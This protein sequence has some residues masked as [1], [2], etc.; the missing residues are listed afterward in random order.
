MARIFDA[1]NKERSEIAYINR[2]A[3]GNWVITF[4][5]KG[6]CVGRSLTSYE[7]LSDQDLT[8]IESM[9]IKTFDFTKDPFGPKF[10]EMES[11]SKQLCY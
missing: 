11:L 3:L 7:Q 1:I 9:G 6:N 8:T 10:K 2:T 4:V 5:K